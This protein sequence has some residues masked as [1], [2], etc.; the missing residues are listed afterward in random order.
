MTPA[1]RFWSAYVAALV[2]L[3]LASCARP[4]RAAE[5]APGVR[6]LLTHPGA[7]PTVVELAGAIRLTDGRATSPG[8]WIKPPA[9][10]PDLAGVWIVPASMLSECKP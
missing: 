8:W 10:R 6:C 2:A 1:G 7:A 4:A 3:G 9:G 5:L